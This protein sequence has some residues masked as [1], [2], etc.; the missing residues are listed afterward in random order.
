MM[1]DDNAARLAAIRAR[2][3]TLAARLWRVHTS[4]HGPVTITDGGPGW[5]ARVKESLPE[6]TAIG[7]FYA[8]APDDV[9]WLLE[10]LDAAEQAR[11]QARADACNLRCDLAEARETHR[12]SL[13]HHA[14]RWAEDQTRLARLAALEQAARRYDAAEQHCQELMADQ[15]WDGDGRAEALLE[16]QAAMQAIR[17]SVVALDAAEGAPD[18]TV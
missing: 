4:I 15:H 14:H 13:S 11:D 9:A 18:G 7:S 10:R 8:H 2:L 1:P 17:R 12:Q 6:K 16:R 5:V 3:G